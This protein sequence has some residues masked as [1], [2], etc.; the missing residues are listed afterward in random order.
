M[1]LSSLF[2]PAPRIRARRLI[3]HGG[4]AC[5]AVLVP[6]ALAGTGAAAQTAAH[7][8]AQGTTPA[9]VPHHH[10][11]RAA[12]STSASL[13]APG[14]HTGSRHP[15][16]HHPGASHPGAHHPPS[17][18]A[19]LH[20][21]GPSL[22]G[23]APHHHHVIP[24]RHAA[25]PAAATGAAAGVSAGVAVGTAA[26][27]TTGAPLPT[28]AGAPPADKGTVTGLPLPRFAALRADEVNMR[29]GPGQRYPIAWV[30]HR[31]D[32]PVKIEREFDVWRLVEDSDGQKGWVH[33]ATLVG[34]RT[35]VV[36]GLPPVAPA[37]NGPAPAAAA[38][39]DGGKPAAPALPP[40]TGEHFDTRIVSRL[41]DP[42]AAST[43]PGA[44]ILR[45]AP[46]GT[47]A[48]VAVLKPGSVGTFRA[49]AAGTIWC[50]VGV[51]HYAGWLDRSSVWGLLPQETIPPS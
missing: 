17:H 1:T 10:H 2:I 23:P 33:Q 37:Q 43:I 25:L 7:T 12:T 50:R 35:F 5:A 13:A 51:Q 20:H 14:H 39:P 21:A 28:P 15:G 3:R 26:G 4:M 11:H 34:A 46:D 41:S 40:A 18:P 27:A 36:P 9:I 22:G 19:G 31:R 30:Y 42:A 44:I 16:S 24:P 32:L 38:P 6:T 8:A 49:C 48:V 29:S 47:S 45:A